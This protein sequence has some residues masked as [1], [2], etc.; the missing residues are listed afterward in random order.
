MTVDAAPPD[1]FEAATQVV[2]KNTASLYPLWM[3]NW[4]DNLETARH[5]D[6]L[7]VLYKQPPCE[8]ALIVGR[9]PSLMKNNH[10][11]LL[12]RRPFKGKIVASDGALPL[13]AERLIC[14]DFSMTVDGSEV[15]TK[16]FVGPTQKIGPKLKAVLPVTANSKVVRACQATGA[17]IFWYIPI[18]DDVSMNISGVTESLQLQ[19]VSAKNTGGLSRLNGAGNCGLASIVFAVQILRAKEVVL[20]GM[21]SGYDINTKL[22]DLH[23]HK[24]LMKSLRY[25]GAAV[26]KLYR[27]Y[28]TPS[29]GKYCIVDPVFE[30]YRRIFLQLAKQA[31]EVGT[32]IVNCTEGGCLYDDGIDAMPFEKYLAR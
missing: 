4:A 5:G 21:D 31:A 25:D 30:T 20:I 22:E 26:A 24:V 16:W 14:P 18:L 13:L 17:H 7:D 8:K 2:Q 19:T 1:Q 27:I 28:Y 12:K 23:Y 11:E 29:I 32:K 10:V 6:S 3:K 9:G 15:L